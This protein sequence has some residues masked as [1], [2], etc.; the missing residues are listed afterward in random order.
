MVRV[1]KGLEGQMPLTE[2]VDHIRK[3]IEA[4][5]LIPNGEVKI[6]VE[7]KLQ[8]VLNK[9]PGWK[10]IASVSEV[11]SGAAAGQNLDFSIAEIS[12]FKYAPI[13][14]CDVERS[15]SRFKSVLRNN[16]LRFTE[17]NIMF[18]IVSH[19]NQ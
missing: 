10:T 12:N 17:E 4:V 15:F 6:R 5:S 8:F 1:I 3:V 9:N 14:S 2:S 18:Y 19:C 7:E 16:R 13:T 11:L